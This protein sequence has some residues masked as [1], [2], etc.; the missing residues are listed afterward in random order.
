MIELAEGATENVSTR[1]HRFLPG[2]GVIVQSLH[3]RR[4]ACVDRTAFICPNRP[5]GPV[6]LE[7]WKFGALS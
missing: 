3:D 5:S 7:T 2:G 6:D 1:S 4:Q